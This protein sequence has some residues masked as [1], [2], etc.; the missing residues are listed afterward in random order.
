MVFDW[1]VVFCLYV[2]CLNVVGEC[3]AN[4]IS[5]I[6]KLFI[7]LI[8]NRLVNIMWAHIKIYT[9]K[10]SPL[11]LYLLTVWWLYNSLAS[12]TAQHDAATLVPGTRTHTVTPAYTTCLTMETGRSTRWPSI[13]PSVGQV[14]HTPT[15]RVQLPIYDDVRVFSTVRYGPTTVTTKTE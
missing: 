10:S 13:A 1:R 3:C 11:M 12:R 2:F 14:P 8:R 4:M 6:F 15:C 7:A 5:L 9:K